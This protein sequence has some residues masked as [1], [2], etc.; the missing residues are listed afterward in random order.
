MDDPDDSI[1][2]TTEAVL[3]PPY[4]MVTTTAT[5]TAVVVLVVVPVFHTLSIFSGT[6]TYFTASSSGGVW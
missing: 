2:T 5:C 4:G 3:I 6:G 1:G